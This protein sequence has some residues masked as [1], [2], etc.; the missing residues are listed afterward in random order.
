MLADA[1]F[2]AMSL[3]CGQ[4]MLRVPGIGMA[5][6]AVQAIIGVLPLA[7]DVT[8]PVATFCRWV[9]PGAVPFCPAARNHGRAGA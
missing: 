9:A 5:R 4:T 2:T 3:G 8:H 1:N 7:Q 6:A